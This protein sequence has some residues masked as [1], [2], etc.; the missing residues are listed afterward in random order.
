MQVVLL[1]VVAFL[2]AIDQYSLT[3]T[4]QRPI[5][6]CP[7]I[8][9]ILGDVKTGLAVGGTYEL[10]MIGNMPVGGA[11]PPNAV[12]GGIV[13][14]VFAVRSGMDV[15]AA[16]GSSIIF[17]LF[18]QYAVT[19]TFSFMSYL[20]AKADKAA[21]NADENGIR[22]VQIT[23]ACILGA[24]FALFAVLAY[25]GGGALGEVL[26]TYSAKISWLMGGL[27]AAG[28]MMRYVG[29]AVLLRIMLASDMWGIYFAGFACAAILGNIPATSGATLVLVAFIGV[30]IAIYDYN[31]NIKIKGNGG[32]SD[33]I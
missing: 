29:F 12:L 4:F 16:L 18:G 21:E 1:A 19:L 3:E 32:S 10:M 22:N 2:L 5:I 33:G 17:A 6:A 11:Q 30:A 24:L 25:F 27:S 14:M 20:M 15:E 31:T 7:I 13:A 28:G 26:T 9:L 23:S 8:G